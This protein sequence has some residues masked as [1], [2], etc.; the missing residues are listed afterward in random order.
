MAY[1]AVDVVGS[2]SMVLGTVV[3]TSVFKHWP[4]R[5]IIATTQ[6]ALVAVSFLDLL[7]VLRLNSALGVPEHDRYLR[8]ARVF[9]ERYR[10]PF[11]ESDE[12]R[13]NGAQ[14]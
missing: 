11:P 14:P 8:F 10:C 7:W 2:L 5:R 13:E 4:Y 3:Y 6:A 1:S 12:P 9:R